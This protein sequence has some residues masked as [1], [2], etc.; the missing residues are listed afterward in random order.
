M[1][2]QPIIKAD[3]LKYDQKVI[4]HSPTKGAEVAILEEKKSTRERTEYVFGVSSGEKITDA[5]HFAILT[6]PQ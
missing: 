4:I 1:K 6:E 5:S 2:W 3:R